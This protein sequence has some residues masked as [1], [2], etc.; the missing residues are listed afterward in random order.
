M[1]AVI[2]KWRVDEKLDPD[3]LAHITTTV[4]EQPGFVRGYWGQEVESTSHAHAVVVLEDEPSA[5]ALAAGVLAAIPSAELQV[6]Q[7]LADAS[8][9]S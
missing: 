1:F 2:G 5:Q 7:V 8:S 9:G 3:Q 4:R 6:V